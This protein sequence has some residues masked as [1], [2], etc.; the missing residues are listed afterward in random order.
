M[1]TFV[2]SSIFKKYIMGLTGLGLAVFVMGHMAGNLL[3]FISPEAYNT[4]GYKLT[5]NPAYPL[6]AWGL[7]ACLALHAI[8]GILL[9]RENQNAS[10]GRYAVQ[11]DEAKKATT[12][13]QTMM[14]TG[15]LIAF[16]VTTHLWGMKYGAYYEVTYDG[17]VMRD[18]HRLVIEV[19]QSPLNIFW[20]I[21]SLVFLSIHMTH[22][23]AS[24]FQSLGLNHPKY[25][26]LVSVAGKAYAVVVGLGFISQPIYVFFVH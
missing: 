17:V 9:A 2:K 22:G 18:L 13:S 11:P 14:Y 6:I 23:V 21:V 16:F 7:V 19:F 3:I 24:T 20:Y 8:M 26:P 12:A 15:I 25:T 1:W 5:S 10:G 4:Y